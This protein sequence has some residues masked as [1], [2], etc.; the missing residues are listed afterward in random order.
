[1]S[2]RTQMNVRENCAEMLANV[3]G[4]QSL[5]LHVVPH[6]RYCNEQL[7]DLSSRFFAWI[8]IQSIKCRY[9]AIPSQGQR[10]FDGRR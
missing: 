2:K 1:M 9:R 4:E 10:R 7:D 6:G 5:Q 3:T 8:R